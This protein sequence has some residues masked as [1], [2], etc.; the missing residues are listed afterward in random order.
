MAVF[1]HNAAETWVDVTN[2][3]DGNVVASLVNLVSGSNT[4]P[5]V[6]VRF[7]SE[8]GAMDFFVLMGP[9]PKDTIKQ[10]ASLTGVPILPQVSLTLDFYLC[11]HLTLVKVTSYLFL[12]SISVQGCVKFYGFMRYLKN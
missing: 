1:W 10:Y 8:S 6:D 5:N 11:Q 4:Q 7:M 12:Q 2:S 9:S 3:K